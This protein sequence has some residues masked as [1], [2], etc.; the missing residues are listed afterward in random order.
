MSD[1]FGSLTM[2]ARALAAQ[3]A[4]LSVVGQNVAN[5]NTAGYA[6]RVVDLA[7]VAPADAR[8]AGDGVEVQAIR[9]ARDLQVEARLREEV[10]AESEQSALA[11]GLSA[12]DAVIGTPG[13]SLDADITAFFDAFAQLAEDPTSASS[14]EGVLAQADSLASAFHDMAGRLGAA[15]SDADAGMR[16]AV[17]QVNALAERLASLNASIAVAGSRESTAMLQYRDDQI[18]AIE[19]LSALIDVHAIQREDGGF[20]VT[21][22]NGRPLVVGGSA[23][24][25]Q[26]ATSADGTLALRSQDV[27]VTAEATGGQI[28]GLRQLRDTLVPDYLDRLDALAYTL[29]GQVNAVH[30]AGFDLDGNPA[31]PFF[32]PLADQRGAAASIAVAP[33]VAANA[34]LVAAAGAPSAGDNQAARAIAALRE[35][36]LLD[37]GTATL[38]DGFG[39]LA[40]RVGQDTALA[41]QRQQS[42]SDAVLQIRT[43]RESVSGVSLD[44]EAAQMMK[45]QRAY[46]ASARYFQSVDAA[47]DILMQMVGGS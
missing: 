33:D 40:Y 47:L 24:P 19:S 44:E 23:V 45:F 27:E 1:L 22:G 14:R 41:Q 9:S 15:R 18:Q 7:S 11:Q 6:R 16:T 35:A 37:R 25:I 5:V 2:A 21:F 42:R 31:Q 46:E 34:R 30:A 13:A 43:L 20:D 36:R 17:D 3:S 8:S 10:S 29:A 12:V 38:A 28:G 26:A 32:A 4:G 39:T